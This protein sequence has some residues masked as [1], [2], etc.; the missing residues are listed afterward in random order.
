M[1]QFL[2]RDHQAFYCGLN[3]AR[4]AEAINNNEAVTLQ[5][6][7]YDV[8]DGALRT[9]DG[10]KVLMTLNIG[11][12]TSL[13]YDR[14]CDTF[15]FSCGNKLYST[16]PKFEKYT[17]LGTLTGTSRPHYTMFGTT[18]LIASGGTL[19][20]ISGNHE[21]LETIDGAP[22]ASSVT[23][24]SGRAVVFST[25]SDLLSY[26]AIG[27]A[28]SWKYDATHAQDTSQPQTVN[29]GYKD[30]GALVAV[31]FL[32]K[33]L[34]A[35]KEDGR[36]YKVVGEPGDSSFAV[37]PISQ[38]AY[39]MSPDA[40]VNI[41]SKSYY[42]GRSGFNSFIPTND[43]G[44]IAPFQEGININGQL[45]RNMDKNCQLWHVP[46]RKQIWIKS[47]DVPLVYIYHYV[48]RYSDGRGAFTSRTL[49]YS[50]NDVCDCE[51]GTYIAY[52]NAIAVLDPTIDTDNGMQ[53]V[54]SIVGA[55]RLASKHSILVMNR[56]VVTYN[57]IAG[58]AL[59]TCGKKTKQID[60]SASM[61][62]ISDAWQQI[63]ESTEGI[64]AQDYSR[65][66]RVGGGSNKSVQVALTI[67]K[68]AIS[69]RQFDYEY[70]EV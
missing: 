28:A 32:S 21:K 59:V 64:Y 3:W 30:K 36:A 23:V 38:T 41:D 51:Y 19:Q 27:D 67:P 56:L 16:T 55:N 15:Y 6:C 58:Y 46:S 65:S 29:V 47:Q 57:R 60:L 1:A 52:G 10:I 31:D 2:T 70:L 17:E 33:V 4:N 9:V 37:E 11:D 68:G 20:R 62:S 53:I 25:D 42:L 34:L 39:C 12:I 61:T 13:Y 22:K 66:Y 44:D 8:E 50:V 43:Y 35:Y 69:L 14:T 45:M 48:P 49:C 63:D 5:N 26:S 40:T 7:E 18:C 24:R 54:T